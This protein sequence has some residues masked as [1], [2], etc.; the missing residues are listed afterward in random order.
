MP[1]DSLT[2]ALSSAA[3]IGW[4]FLNSN[5]VIAFF[6]GMAG[7]IGGAL[8]AQRIAQKAQKREELLKELRHTNAGITISHTICNSAL[9]LKK[10]HVKPMRESFLKDQSELEEFEIKR[11]SGEVSEH[12]KFKFEPNM[13]TFPSPTLPVESLKHIAFQEI[14]P[15]GRPLALVAMIEEALVELTSSIEKRDR[16]IRS[17]ARGDI[18]E[19]LLSYYYF[20]RPMEDGK[21]NQE[22]PDLVEAI[23]S[24]VDQL[25]FFSYQLCNDLTEHG[26]NVRKSLREKSPKEAPHVVEADFSRA[27]ESGLMPT[28]DEYEDWLS[29]FMH[30]KNK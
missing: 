17:F 15:T 6:G 24:Y 16:L 20:G 13:R 18:P 29:M 26:K 11:E 30:T 25:A 19:N 4:T 12:E 27:F 7:A 9:A 8:G 10:Q 3:N 23:Y 2:D 5:V 28:S 14:S 21:V 22:I 1:V